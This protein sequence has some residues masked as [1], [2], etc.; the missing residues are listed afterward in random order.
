MGGK[1]VSELWAVNQG[2]VKVGI[3]AGRVAKDVLD[4]RGNQLLSEGFSSRPFKDSHPVVG[5]SATSGLTADQRSQGV[6]HRLGC[7]QRDTCLGQPADKSAPGNRLGEIL[8]NQLSHVASLFLARTMHKFSTAATKSSGVLCAPTT[9]HSVGLL[10]VP[11]STFA[12]ADP[13]AG[14]PRA[15]SQAGAFVASL[16]EPMHNPG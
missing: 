5:T 8:G 10:N 1:N 12:G 2:F 9:L 6:K 14:A 4:S 16:Q 3:A 7:R 13:Q 15:P 11:Y